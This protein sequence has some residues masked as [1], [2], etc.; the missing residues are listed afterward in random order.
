[1]SAP[2]LGEHTRDVLREFCDL[3]E[4]EIER[5]RSRGVVDCA[6][7]PVSSGRPQGAD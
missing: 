1:M 6:A 2:A 7:T 5:L 4:V 3:T